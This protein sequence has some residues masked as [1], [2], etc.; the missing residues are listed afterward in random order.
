MA[1]PLAKQAQKCTSDAET[2]KAIKVAFEVF[3]IVIE[4]SGA[5]ALAAILAGKINPVGKTIGIVCT[6][7][8]I[9]A[10]TFKDVLDGKFEN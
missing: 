9:D 5:V 7:G 3:K 8:N 4:P 2:A 10:N 1:K 6:G